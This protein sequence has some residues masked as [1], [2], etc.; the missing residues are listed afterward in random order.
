MPNNAMSATKATARLTY[1]TRSQQGAEQ[2]TR[3]GRAAAKA[4]ATGAT[5]VARPSVRLSPAPCWP[6]EKAM[7]AIEPA[8]R[9]TG[10]ARAVPLFAVI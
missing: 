5:M 6:N 4:H 9:T 3:P 1:Y 8:W 10:E 2:R 7:T